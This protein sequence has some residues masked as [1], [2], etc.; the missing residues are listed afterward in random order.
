M[1]PDA[2]QPL[3]EHPETS[4]LLLDFD[5]TLS[6]IVE[7]PT[8]AR[9]LPEGIILDPDTI[10]TQAVTF[11]PTGPGPFT[12]QYKFNAENGQGWMTVTLTGEGT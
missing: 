4:A 10:A 9:P 7:D 8:A 3:V 1:L 5:G 2:L 12:G 6:L 11:T